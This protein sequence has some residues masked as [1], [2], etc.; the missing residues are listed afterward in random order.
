MYSFRSGATVTLKNAVAAA[1]ALDALG[2][3][4]RVTVYRRIGERVQIIQ[5]NLDG[6][7]AGLHADL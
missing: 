1:G 5:V 2:W 6:I 3:P 4:T 7:Y